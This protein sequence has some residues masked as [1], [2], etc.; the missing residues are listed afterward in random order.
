MTEVVVWAA[1]VLAFAAASLVV[2]VA[3]RR[4][5]FARAERSRLAA[6]T[7]LRPVALALVEGEP[8]DLAPLGEREAQTLAGLLARYARWLSGD[9]LGHIAAFFEETGGVAR[10]LAALEDRRAWRRATAAHVL[11]DMAARAAVPA[12]LDSLEDPA[13]EVRAAAARSLGRLGAARAAEPLVLALAERRIP[14][15]VAGQ[16]LLTVGPPA[17]P[18]LT[19]L[20]GHPSAEAR[21]FA[22]ELVGLVGDASHAALLVER[23]RDTSAEVRAKACRALGRVG[24]DEAA[25]ELRTA[26]RDRIPFVRT[27]AATALGLI[28][29]RDAVPA[30]LAEARDETFFEAAQAAARALARIDPAT[31]VAAAADPGAGPHLRE[32]ADLLAVRAA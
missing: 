9:A 10:E 28:G 32:A 23:L 14:R 19:A 22:V 4:L 24:A 16:A 13:R 15:A 6:E 7:L 2:A 3:L 29:D 21:A 31:V 26:L 27:T 20:V 1:A 17:L 18:G 8:V 12:L 30:L 11:G 25:A 5:H